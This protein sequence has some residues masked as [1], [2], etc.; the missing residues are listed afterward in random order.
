MFLSTEFQRSIKPL[1]I[2]NSIFNTGL[3]E[4][5]VDIKINRIGIIGS[6]IFG[7]F[8]RKKIRRLTLQI[9]T[10]IRTMNQL[11]IPMNLAKQFGQYFILYLVFIVISMIA[12]D[13]KWF[14]PFGSNYWK[15]F[16]FFYIIRYPLIV[17][18]L[19]DITF[20]YWMRQI[21]FGQLN[22]LL[23]GMLTTTIHSPQHK[24]VLCMRNRMSDSPSSGIHRTDKSNEDLIKIRKAKEIHLELIKCAR[25]INDAYGL[26]ILLSITTAFILI[27]IM[28]YN[29][30]YFFII[31]DYRTQ[32]YLILTF[33]YWIFYFA[34]KIIIICHVCART[35]AEICDFTVQVIKN[36]LTLTCCGI[37]DLDHTLIRNTANVIGTVITYLVILI[38][39]GNISQ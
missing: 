4:Y 5:F 18:L 26:H 27:T 11:H 20:V 21:K 31:L 33:I 2:M 36:P 35:I 13:C 38:Q 12:I 14:I 39:I 32:L 24:R 29:L 15:I 6:I 30:Y 1:I 9:E 3:M 7:V 37:F 25:N 23:K 19:V 22:E 28:S 34:I 8:R 10:C 16:I 17:L